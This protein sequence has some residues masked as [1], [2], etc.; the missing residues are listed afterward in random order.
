MNDKSGNK[1]YS[2]SMNYLV[3][4]S[5]SKQAKVNHANNKMI[6]RITL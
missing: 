5:S 2:N 6:G 3:D 4:G 1:Y